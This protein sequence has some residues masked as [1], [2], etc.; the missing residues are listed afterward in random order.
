MC[1]YATHYITL[2]PTQCRVGRACSRWLCGHVGSRRP[3]PFPDVT[4]GEREVGEPVARYIVLAQLLR[5]VGLTSS[6]PPQMVSWPFLLLLSWPVRNHIVLALALVLRGQLTNAWGCRH[7]PFI[8]DSSD[9][10]AGVT[11][12]GSWV[13]EQDDPSAG[14]FFF[15]GSTMRTSSNGDSVEFAFKG[16]SVRP[17]GYPL[18]LRSILSEANA[19]CVWLGTCRIHRCGLR[20]CREEACKILR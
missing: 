13:A 20:R 16:P 6:L 8:V 7:R 3:R 2:V 14:V 1:C 18:P 12:N 11:F 9:L 5:L 19:C 4:L 10:N 17:H 15:G